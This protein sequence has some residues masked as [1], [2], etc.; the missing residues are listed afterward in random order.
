MS[1]ERD[2]EERW[3]GYIPEVLAIHA[4]VHLENPFAGPQSGRLSFL[5]QE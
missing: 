4:S 5:Q 3:R 1:R 2:R